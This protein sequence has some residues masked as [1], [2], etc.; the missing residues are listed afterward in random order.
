MK[1]LLAM[2]SKGKDVSDFFPD[3]VKN[4]IVKSIEVKKMVYNYLVHYAD[5][6]PQCRELAL[7]SI[8]SFQKDLS[9]PNQLFRGLALRVMTSIRVPD[10]IQI[11]LMAVKKCGTDT[12]PYVRKCAATAVTK[13]YSMDSEQLQQLQQILEKLLSD[14]STMVL[15][16][17]IAAF[18]EISPT[19]YHLIHPNYRKICHL[20]ADL[21][22]WSQI[23]CLDVLARYLRNQFTDP[24]PGARTVAQHNVKIRS[25]SAI[26]GDQIGSTSRITMKRTVVRKAFY[27]DEEDVIDEEDV[28]MEAS[29]FT[30]SYLSNAGYGKPSSTG[31]APSMVIGGAD[32]DGDMEP[33]H[34]LALKSAY[35]LLRSRNAGVVLGVCNLQNSCG[36]QS[37]N[38]SNQL[39][40]ALVRILRNHREIQFV[41]LTSI[42]TMARERP[43]I[44]RPYMSEFFMKSD[45]PVFNRYD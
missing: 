13:I 41:V 10:I 30:P 5:F 12:S 35:P 39:A 1:W 7:L 11:Q 20:L 42:I 24:A 23:S 6:N 28:D 3:V 9:G 44:F 45:D 19:S 32:V 22:E 14:S 40:K 8:N 21:D 29:S 33:D 31:S 15:G 16:S 17:A 26:K 25:L 18:N 36:S 2:L 38:M 34:R 37:D 43:Y 4:V 27:S